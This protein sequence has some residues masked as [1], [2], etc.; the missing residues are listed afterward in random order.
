MVV[1]YKCTECGEIVEFIKEYKID[2]PQEIECPKCKS[3]CKR[4]W[5]VENT[6]AI[7]IPHH[8]SAT[9]S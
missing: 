8:M 9:R 3:I 5:S 1:D 7:I 2:F 6:G 4:K